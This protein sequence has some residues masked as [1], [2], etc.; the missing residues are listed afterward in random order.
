[1]PVGRSVPDLRTGKVT[2][3]GA[4]RRDTEPYRTCRFPKSCL[5]RCTC[6]VTVTAKVR[7]V[8]PRRAAALRVA[9]DVNGSRIPT[10]SRKGR[11]KRFWEELR[12]AGS[13]HLTTAR[14]VLMFSIITN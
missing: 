10:G 11:E 7:H 2:L 4:A 12:W 6:L 14:A 13:G 3:Q 9:K 1:V 8:P 5:V